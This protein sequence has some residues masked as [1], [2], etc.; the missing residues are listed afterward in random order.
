MEYAFVFLIIF[1]AALLLTAARKSPLMAR[2]SQKMGLK[3]AKKAAREIAG[4]VA[5]VGLA[6]ILYCMIALLKG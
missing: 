3:E 2:T 5:A 1:G 6:L 4:C